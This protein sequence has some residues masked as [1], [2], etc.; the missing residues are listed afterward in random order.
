VS[1]CRLEAKAARELREL[2]GALDLK[3][4][5]LLPSDVSAQHRH[6]CCTGAA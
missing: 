2:K 4:E 1:L 6:R 5:V 3:T